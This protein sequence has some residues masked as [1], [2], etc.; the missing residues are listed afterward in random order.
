MTP[1][2]V[3]AVRHKAITAQTENDTLDAL[4]RDPPSTQAGGPPRP[5]DGRLCSDTLTA[6]YDRNRLRSERCRTRRT[7][8][9]GPLPNRGGELTRKG[10][11]RCG[12]RGDSATGFDKWPANRI[13]STDGAEFGRFP[14]A[15]YDNRNGETDFTRA[16]MYSFSIHPATVSTSV[17]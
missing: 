13:L 3:K 5:S 14:N 4:M 9:T 8:S 16:T 1:I 12:G 7:S 2:G 15:G 6:F 11:M 10:R 17:S